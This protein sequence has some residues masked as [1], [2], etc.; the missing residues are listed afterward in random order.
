MHWQ[1][2]GAESVLFLSPRSDFAPGKPIRG[3]IPVI[4]PWFGPRTANALSARTDGPAHGFARTEDWTVAFAALAGDDLHLTLTLAPNEASRALGFG[5][6]QLALEFILGGELRLRLSVANTG[7]TPFAFEEALHTY[8][9]VGDATQISISGFLNTEYL[10]KTD[11]L[12]RKLQT[13]DPIRLTSETDRPY[14][15]TAA[16]ISLTDPALHRSLTVA[17]AN[18]QTTVLWNPWSTKSATMPDMTPE[19]W[20]HMCCIETANAA[21]N[22]ITLAPQQAHTME[23]HIIIAP[24]DS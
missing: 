13:E 23:A 19:A 5:D 8:L 16:T 11:H 14:L 1:P 20:L 6:F 17:K 2:I 24:L 12:A 22:R 15:N 21:D 10:D 4:F 3:G 9:R 7:T 18:S